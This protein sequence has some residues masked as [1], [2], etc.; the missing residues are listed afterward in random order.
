MLSYG[1]GVLKRRPNWLLRGLV[2]ISLGIHLIIFLQI[3]GLY[4]SNALTCIE[5]T[6]KDVSRPTQ[7]GIPR[8]P[9]RSKPPPQPQDVKRLKITQRSIPHFKPVKIEPPERELPDSLVE[10]IDIPNFPG[11]NISDW[12]PGKQGTDSD[13]YVTSTSYLEMV[14]L[15]IER[16]KRYP[17]IARI[18]QIERSVTVQFVIM[19]NGQLKEARV[20]KTSRHKVLDT[21]AITGVMDAA[22]F[23]KPPQHLFN[24]EIV[25]E[26][27]IVFELT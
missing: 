11:V 20:V 25:V 16:H 19:P 24:G 17:D 1:E 21:A 14:R 8:P 15:K 6:L 3:S 26:L 9:H 13:D 12:T 2:G 7:R 18:R 5:L 10:R 27:T 23:P 22:P 4:S